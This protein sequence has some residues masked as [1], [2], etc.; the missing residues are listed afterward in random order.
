V[1]EKGVRLTKIN[2]AMMTRQISDLL[3]Q[4]NDLRIRITSLNPLRPENAA[5][6][7]EKEALAGFVDR[8]KRAP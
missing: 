1:T 7:W 2:P 3:N 6:I 5:D 8:L 4:G